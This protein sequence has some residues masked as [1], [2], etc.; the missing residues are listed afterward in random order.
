LTETVANY[1][2]RRTLLIVLDNCEHLLQAC[3]HLVDT[4]LR[5]SP[6]LF[7]L[8]TS[9]EVL[10]IDGELIYRVPSLSIPDLNRLPPPDALTQYEAVRLFVE[11][12]AL[13]QPGFALTSTTAP[14]VVAIC[15]RLDGIPLA[16]ELAAARLGSVPLDVIAA[17]LDDRFRLLVGGN[18]TGLPR[19]QTLRAAMAWSYDLLSE[20]EQTVLRRLAVFAGGFSVEAAEA[21]CAGDGIDPGDVLELLTRLV[22]KSLV[23]FD[24]REGGARY[25]LL[26]T[27]RQYGQEK[28][29]EAGDTTALR[30]RHRD[31]FLALAERGELALRSSAQD[32][33]LARFETEHDNLRAALEWST[34]DEGGAEAGLRLAAGLHGFWHIRG[35]WN[36]G[37]EW[38]ERALARSDEAPVACL[39]KA[40]SGIAVIMRRLGEYEPAIPLC[41]KGLA[42]CRE[43]G[44][45]KYRG[46]LLHHFRLHACN[47]GDYGRARVLCEEA[48]ALFRETGDDWFIGTGLEQLAETVRL[49]GHYAEADAYLAQ[50][51]AIYRECGDKFLCSHVLI[52]RGDTALRQGGL[53]QAVAFFAEGLTLASA[54]SAKYLIIEGVNGLGLIACERGDHRRA[55]RM[56]GA[57]EAL[58]AISSFRR[59]HP[60]QAF[61][62]RHQATTQAVLGDAAFAAAWAEGQAMTLDQAIEYALAPDVQ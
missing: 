43:L 24:E 26:E 21:V 49:Q 4:L 45:K 39:P 5:T 59:E 48:L 19:H 11:R 42:I 6:N 8:A 20:P 7:V 13:R 16:I 55:A 17:R 33:W 36:E 31:F 50:A 35:Y 15:T 54:V 62:E 12:A 25:G 1:L 27:V 28:L 38:L 56:F 53:E 14:A 9:R 29:A 57:A 34:T 52:F 30:R 60:E 32:A 22:E 46:R 58:G 3:T 51:L 18:R 23:L 2:R 40:I 41:E 37:R 47:L 44:E 61:Y 10:G